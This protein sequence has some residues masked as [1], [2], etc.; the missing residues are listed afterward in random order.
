MQKLRAPQTL[1]GH[2]VKVLRHADMLLEFC[3]VLRNAPTTSDSGYFSSVEPLVTRANRRLDIILTAE[4]DV[5]PALQRTRCERAKDEIRRIRSCSRYLSISFRR[6]R[7]GGLPGN[8]YCHRRLAQVLQAFSQT[9]MQPHR[10]FSFSSPYGA[11]RPS[12]QI[13]TFISIPEQCKISSF[14]RSEVLDSPG[15]HPLTCS[16]YF[17]R[18]GFTNPCSTPHH[19]PQR[20]AYHCPDIIGSTRRYAAGWYGYRRS[21]QKLA[22]NILR[23]WLGRSSTCATRSVSQGCH[24]RVCFDVDGITTPF[25]TALVFCFDRN[26]DL[27]Q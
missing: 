25:T 23:S 3:T 20:S 14:L 5:A 15:C 22:R 7:S 10:H 1:I 13:L 17:P 24:C 16:T 2:R 26:L 27:F 12:R 11:H 8:L 6:S 21:M 18:R 19:S 9:I 4:L